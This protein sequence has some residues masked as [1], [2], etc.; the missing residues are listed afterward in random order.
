MNHPCDRFSCPEWNQGQC[1]GDGCKANPIL[2]NTQNNNT[3]T[4]EKQ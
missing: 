1:F 4:K 2:D 3:N